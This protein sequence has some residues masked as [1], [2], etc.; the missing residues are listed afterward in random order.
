MSER[1]AYAHPAIG[2]LTLQS[3]DA[4]CG[5]LHGKITDMVPRWR[6]DDVMA[7]FAD[8]KAVREAILALIE[9]LYAKATP[10]TGQ[11]A[12]AWQMLTADPRQP[13]SFRFLPQ[14]QFELD[15]AELEEDDAR[16]LQERIRIWWLAGEG[17]FR[18]AEVSIF[19]IADLETKGDPDFDE[20]P[21][22]PMAPSFAPK[23]PSGQTLVVMPKDRSTKLN[24]H[25]SA[26]KE[27]VDAALPVVVARDVA[28]IRRTLHAEFPHAENA[29]D[30]LLRDLREGRP[31][32]LRPICLVG[33]PGSGKS[34]L[35]RRVGDLTRV[36]DGARPFAYRY[37][38]SSASDN[39]FGGVSKAWGNTEASVPARAVLLSKTANP[40]VLIEELDKAADRNWSGR[41]VDAILPF[42]EIESSSRFRD[43]SL[44]A[45]IDI[46]LIT[47]IATCNSVEKLPEPLRDRMRIIRIPSP[48]LQHLAP[49]AVQVMRDLAIEDEARW[50]D[51]PLASDE[52]AVIGK[53]WATAG[54]SMRKLQKIVAAT[55][56]ARDSYAPR[57]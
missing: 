45:E 49:L 32:V 48:T 56:E 39:Q 36:A 2:L 22:Y 33:S 20:Q 46:S 37:D 7:K 28:K 54:F 21:A 14:L 50:G 6:L 4:A 3:W 34:R 17:A 24:N 51:A 5:W 42:L 23:M 16:L 18:S 53:A 15:N 26:F 12:L 40:V 41:L 44:D 43:P 25:N 55:L 57:H 27:M 11:L 38:G 10:D 8:R 47:Y 29:V 52:L 19:R 1:P 13:D 9:D 35:A 30:L 31:V